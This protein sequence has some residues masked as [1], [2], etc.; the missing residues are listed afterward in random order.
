MPKAIKTPEPDYTR[1]AGA[2]L[3][4]CEET[5]AADRLLTI[6]VQTLKPPTK[7]QAKHLSAPGVRLP[8]RPK[9]I[10]TATLSPSEV[11]KLS[12]EGWIKSLKLSQRLKALHESLFATAELASNGVDLKI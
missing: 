11:I 3:Q 6:F 2:L 4:A 12:H 9:Q 1:I 5:P 10:F 8:T 7:D